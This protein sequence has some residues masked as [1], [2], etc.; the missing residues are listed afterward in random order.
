MPP[1]RDNLGQR[2][3]CADIV[4]V[5]EQHLTLRN[6]HNPIPLLLRS[7]LFV[8]LMALTLF[9]VGPQAGSVDDDGDGN[10][11]I[12]VV[13]SSPS[14]VGEVS[15]AKRVIQRSPNISAVVASVCIGILTPCSGA[16]K[17]DFVSLD[18][19]SVLHA[20]CPLRC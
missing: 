14:V 5:R 10:P 19:R 7:L 13:V 4:I 17:S 16:A 9:V 11:D 15:F 6:F 1:P 12:P 20:S 2:L 8:G 3:R 18:G